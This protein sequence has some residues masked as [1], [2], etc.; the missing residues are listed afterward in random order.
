MHFMKVDVNRPLFQHF[1]H[2]KKKKKS[3]F[4]F[5]F[6][7]LI[8]GVVVIDQ[9]DLDSKCQIKDYIEEV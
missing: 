5:I 3:S 8:W 9:Q 6:L 1:F 2:I 7:S 4:L